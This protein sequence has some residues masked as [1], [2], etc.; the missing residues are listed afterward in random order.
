MSLTVFWLSLLVFVLFFGCQGLD[1]GQAY[2]VV[3]CI[4]Y[5]FEGDEEESSCA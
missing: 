5:A 3:D 4:A 1:L 2:G